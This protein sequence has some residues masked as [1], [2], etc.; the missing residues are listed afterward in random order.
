MEYKITINR[1]EALHAVT[2]ASRRTTKELLGELGFDK[3][4]N[5]MFEQLTTPNVNLL[6][7][8]LKTIFNSPAYAVKGEGVIYFQGDW[9][10]K[11]LE[12]IEAVLNHEELHLLIYDILREEGVNSFEAGLL[13]NLP[14]L[15]G[16]K[17]VF[18]NAVGMSPKEMRDFTRYWLRGTIPG[19][20]TFRK[21]K[22]SVRNEVRTLGDAGRDLLEDAKMELQCSPL[23]LLYRSLKRLAKR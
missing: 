4:F 13:S 18:A 21:L 5:D 8:M 23:G 1:D 22:T 11:M 3:A 9:S 12:N 16:I 17:E 19:V 6:N 14:D 2:R 10:E 15:P 7:I 20:K